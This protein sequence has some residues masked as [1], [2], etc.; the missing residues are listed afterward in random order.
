MALMRIK[1][2][3]ETNSIR[4]TEVRVVLLDI[5]INS[6]GPMSHQELL[7]E[8]RLKSFNRVT[9][10]R[11]L[12]TLLQSSLI[13]R[14]HGVDG[15]WRFCSNLDSKS[16]GCAGNHMHFSCTTCGEM[17]CVLST[18]IPWIDGPKGVEI[19]S[20]ELLIYGKCEQCLERNQ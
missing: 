15:A 4:S 10:Y 17:S 7:T 13:H 6:S 16:S 8:S 19:Y 1:K 14:A 11:T 5:L 9:I 18:P 2:L 12:D 20:K 3:F